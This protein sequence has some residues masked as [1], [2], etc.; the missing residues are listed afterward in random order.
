V[1]VFEE[2][3]MNKLVYFE[4]RP[5]G[6]EKISVGGVE[7]DNPE[8][9]KITQAFKNGIVKSGGTTSFE[10]VVVASCIK[11]PNASQYPLKKDQYTSVVTPYD[12]FSDLRFRMVAPDGE[13]SRFLTPSGSVFKSVTYHELMVMLDTD[14]GVKGD[15][16]LHFGGAWSPNTQAIAWLENQWAKDYGIDTIYIFDPFLDGNATGLESKVN[17]GS[18]IRSN[19]STNAAAFAYTGL[20]AE[21]LKALGGK[22]KSQWNT[23]ELSFNYKIDYFGIDDYDVIKISEGGKDYLPRMCVPNLMLIN[24]SANGAKGKI[25]GSL[26]CEYMYADTSN[27]NNPL[28]IMLDESL[29]ALIG[30]H[31]NAHWNPVT[32]ELSGI[33]IG[34]PD[35]CPP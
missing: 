25:T 35:D 21:L 13:N 15:F 3:P 6:D 10:D 5:L 12:H 29:D 1:L 17:L 26:E 11:V 23:P 19:D 18:N 33:D 8:F 14:K 4:G 24:N 9:G 20:Y 34:E 22:F 28:R 32:P 2:A 7:M 16:L 30:Q 27:P 31:E